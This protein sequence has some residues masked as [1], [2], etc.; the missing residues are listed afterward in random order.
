MKNYESIIETYKAAIPQLL[1]CCLQL[2]NG[3]FVGS[4]TTV[5]GFTVENIY[6][7]PQGYC[8]G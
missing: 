7:E 8:D 2:R 1:Y 4:N 6:R 5:D 3:R